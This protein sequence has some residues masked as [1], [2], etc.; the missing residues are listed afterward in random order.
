M[1]KRNNC[2]SAWN[3]TSKDWNKK[4]Q[5]CLLLI[6]VNLI[7]HNDGEIF[8]DWMERAQA[9]RAVWRGTIINTIH[10]YTKAEAVSIGRTNWHCKSIGQI[11]AEVL[12]IINEEG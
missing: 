4:E 8:A 5:R 1:N 6:I 7:A 12:Q 10:R 11:M 3:T 9:G 2:N